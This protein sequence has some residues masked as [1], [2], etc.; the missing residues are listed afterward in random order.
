[1]SET[2]EKIEPCAWCGKT[3]LLWEH[4]AAY[5][6]QCPL[7]ANANVCL[8]LEDWNRTQARILARRRADFEA[9]AGLHYNANLTLG[10][11][12]I[13]EAWDAYLEREAKDGAECKD[14][15]CPKCGS[16]YFGR[17]VVEGEDGK[18]MVLETVRCHGDSSGPKHE[19]HAYQLAYF[20][21]AHDTEHTYVPAEKLRELVESWRERIGSGD[22]PRICAAELEALITEDGK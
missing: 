3:P 6:C 13:A 14:F 1:M 4:K 18:P 5:A 16:P 11:Q 20:R 7:C 2:P 8:V 10:R 21:K 9:G 12:R 17:D 15:H 19:D 22:W